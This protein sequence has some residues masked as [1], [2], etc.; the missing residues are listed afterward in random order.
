[1]PKPLRLYDNPTP[2]CH[3]VAD[4]GGVPVATVE[5]V[6][7][8]ARFGTSMCRPH[9]DAYLARLIA[10]DPAVYAIRPLR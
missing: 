7:N 10:G 8:F 1:M 5:T 4:C 6:T 2:Y 9:T 3:A